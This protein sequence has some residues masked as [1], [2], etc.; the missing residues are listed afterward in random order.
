MHFA[1]LHQ[2]LDQF[3]SSED[4]NDQQT[5]LTEIVDA[6]DPR[7][8]SKEI[9]DAKK[10]EIR[11]LLERGTFKLILYEE[12][13]FDANFLPGRLVLAINSTEDGK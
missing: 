7:S 6:K 4:D 10:K 5:Y 12:A 13:L 8:T 2:S 1:E 3:S 11:V 9:L